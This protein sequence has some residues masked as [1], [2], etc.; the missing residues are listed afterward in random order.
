MTLESG[1][2]EAAGNSSE[3]LVVCVGNR[4]VGDDAVGC[5]VGDRLE[6]WGLPPRVRLVQLGLGGMQLLDQLRG[7]RLLVVVD[8][9]QWGAPCG[10]VYCREWE[11]LPSLGSAT[12]VS[13]HGIGVREAVEVARLLNP[14][15]APKEVAFVGIEGREFLELGSECSPEVLAAVDEAAKRILNR[16]GS[17][18]D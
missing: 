11:D 3:T 8:A 14:E 13:L 4:W 17:R 7:E 15:Q 5:I 18:E 6:Q 2:V 9:V 1:P 10:T 16:I 12:P